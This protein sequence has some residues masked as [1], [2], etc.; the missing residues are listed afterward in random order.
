MRRMLIVTI[1]LCGLIPLLASTTD[2]ARVSE[3]EAVRIADLWMA[4]D[5]N[6]DWTGLT[7]EQRAAEL[8]RL[9][10]PQ[11]LYLTSKDDLGEKPPVGRALA[12]VVKY[13]NSGWAVISGDDRLEPVVA[14]DRVSPFRWDEPKRNFARHYLGTTMEN[15]WRLIDEGKGPH[16]PHHNWTQLR[17]KLET[18]ESLE[19]ASFAPLAGYV[20]RWTTALWDQGQYY[21]EEV[22]FRNGGTPD[23]PTGCTATAMAMQMRFH[24]WPEWGNGSHSYTDNDGDVR[25]SHSVNYDASSY[26][27]YSMPIANI[28]STNAEVA[29]IMYESGVAVNMN[30]EV[31]GSGAWPAPSEMNTHFRFR[32]T[33]EKDTGDGD[34][35]SSVVDSVMGC[36]PT[37]VS[38]SSHTVLVC[39]Y[40][41]TQAPYHY[42]NA[43]WS[44]NDN[45]WY[46][47]PIMPAGT[48][49]TVDR[50]Y[51]F[52]APN[53]FTYVGESSSGTPNGNYQSP[54]LTVSQGK[55]NTP[56]SGNLWIKAGTYAGKGNTPITFNNPINIRACATLDAYMPGD[57][58]TIGENIQLYP[59]EGEG[60]LRSDFPCIKIVDGGGLAIY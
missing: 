25:Y 37:I 23:I 2:A 51:P 43:G 42:I 39:G 27:W 56:S 46:T 4:M 31:G 13:G 3:V 26:V 50:T 11:V 6:S 45:G 16:E 21:N 22:V 41:T 36:L 54:F 18:T 57:A 30:Y 59:W 20:L 55:I 58:A 44:G 29:E 28:T 38:S 40:R 9:R 48:D 35:I 49:I 33:T 8:A 7:K 32:G 12:Y 5:T 47:L 52:S 34:Y 17:G 10:D 19:T 60:L 24:E 15:W 14:F 1:A 53:M